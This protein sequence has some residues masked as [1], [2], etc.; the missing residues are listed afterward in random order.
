MLADGVPAATHSLLFAQV[1]NA[2]RLWRIHLP[3]DAEV[4]TPFAEQLGASAKRSPE[5]MGG[6]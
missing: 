4:K 5:T 1:D 6:S 3:T 2:M